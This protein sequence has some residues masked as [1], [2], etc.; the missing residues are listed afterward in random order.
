MQLSPLIA[1]SSTLCFGPEKYFQGEQCHPPAK[2]GKVSEFD[3]QLRL[4]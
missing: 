4:L 2:P 3:S 1:E